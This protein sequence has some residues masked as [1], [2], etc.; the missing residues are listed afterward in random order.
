MPQTKAFASPWRVPTLLSLPFKR[1]SQ[2]IS[3]TK[4]ERG[5]S[6]LKKLRGKST[7]HVIKKYDALIAATMNAILFDLAAPVKSA[8]Q[9]PGK[10]IIQRITDHA[11]A[12]PLKPENA[13][14]STGQNVYC[15]S[16]I[17]TH[18]IAHIWK[19]GL[20]SATVSGGASARSSLFFE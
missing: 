10:Q 5:A 1:C 14:I 17:R 3:E 15:V 8:A 20:S 7:T 11:G 13:S 12:V 19:S 9:A 18:R 6:A 16:G 4:I 2:Y